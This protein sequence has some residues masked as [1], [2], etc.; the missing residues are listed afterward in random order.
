[1]S[2]NDNRN[3]GNNQQQ[4]RGNNQQNNNQ[5]YGQQQQYGHNPYGQQQQQYGQQQQHYGQQYSNS[6]PYAAQQGYNEQQQYG[7]Q[8]SA[9]GQQQQQPQ[10]NPYA[11]QQEQQY[12]QHQQQ[13]YGN[14]D[15]YGRGSQNQPRDARNNQ[16]SQ[17]QRNQNSQP[18]IHSRK[19]DPTRSSQKSSP[20]PATKKK[21]QPKPKPVKKKVVASDDW[22]D[23][24]DEEIQ[25]PK[26]TPKPKA[27]EPK[28][29]VETKP[30]AKT[31]VTK[32][33]ESKQASQKTEIKSDPESSDLNSETTSPTKSE[34]KEEITEKKAKK[35]EKKVKPKTETKKKSKKGKG[36]GKKKAEVHDKREHL[37][38][39]FVGHVDAGKSTLSGQILL[40]T[41]QVDER[42]VAKFEKE[43]KDKNRESWWIAY[44]MDTSEEERA[45]GK[46]VECGRA[47]F[48]T[49]EKR[50]TILDAPGHKNYV[51]H[52]I[53]GAA[54]ADVA[55]L[56][57]SARQGEFEAGFN[58]GGQ[59]RE[60]TRLAHTLGIKRV[61]IIVNK[62]DCTAGQP[63]SK[64]RYDFI[65]SKLEPFLKSIG[66]KW[67]DII[68]LPV[69]GQMGLNV[70]ESI[71]DGIC[72][73]Y[74][75]P[76]LLDAF[77]TL[78]KIKRDKKK[79]LRIPIMDRYKDM[80][81]IMAIGKIEA[82]FLQVGDKIRAMPSGETATVAKIIVDDEIVEIAKTGE[83]VVVGLKG[84]NE[85]QL[86]GGHVLCDVDEYTPKVSALSTQLQLLDL[87]EHKPLFSIGYRAVLH[88]HNLQVPCE[89][90][91]IPHK[92]HKKTGKKS[93]RPPPFLK[94]NEPGIVNLK[95]AHGICCEKYSEYQKLGRFTLRDEGKT[96]A[97]GKI[98]DIF[99]TKTD[100]NMM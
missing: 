34:G 4:R 39:V 21:P 70:N 59:T 55:C 12:N 53:S 78:K 65:L 75:G 50:Y 54:Q 52:M 14:A 99:H 63:W 72:D 98:L 87:L 17:N 88:C 6:N 80:G 3:R 73:W 24:S 1:M 11:R 42:T 95:L 86:C 57:I 22:D 94:S 77:D 37:N 83:N 36:K 96:V 23:D 7:Q 79:P 84:I 10:Y 8:Y 45:K 2:W 38:V 25:K 100:N 60:H 76:C 19:G 69:S 9:Y 85:D 33:P 26:P 56:V 5:G 30:A 51:P 66:F 89:V 48:E 81:L 29:K 91:V 20:A 18:Q 97:I 92:L 40:K 74:K 31:T 58:R 93:K 82:N 46:T 43:A 27:A 61:M 15:S 71:P 41:G 16:N 49:K 62:M 64:E 35:E 28:P 13:G 68:V 67:K 90:S 32:A 47:H 44:I